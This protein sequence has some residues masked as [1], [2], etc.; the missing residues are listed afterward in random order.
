MN[1][2]KLASLLATQIENFIKLRQLCGRDYRSQSL[3]LAYFDR[4]LAQEKLKKPHITRPI[5]E[6]YHTTLSHLSPRVQANRMC[7]VRQLCEYLA[8]H[9]VR[10][11]I[12]EP[13]KT[14][15]SSVARKPYIYSASELNQLLTTALELSPAGS[16]R[17]HTYYTLLG[18][19]YSTGIRIR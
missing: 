17:P 1:G 10:T 14:M 15:S 5:I 3:L 19:L 9:D 11:F 8:R 6:R 7:V 4:F 12:P 13:M 16:L 18:L 2:I